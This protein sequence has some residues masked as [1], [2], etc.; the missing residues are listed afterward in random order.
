[1]FRQVQTANQLTALEYNTRIYF[2]RYLWPWGKWNA[3]SHD[4]YTCQKFPRTQ[5]FPTQRKM[6]K[7][8]FVASVIADNDML[9]KTCPL[10]C[11][12]KNH[13]DWEYC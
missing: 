2:F 1:M 7:N 10:K 3:I 4:S 11:R 8:N 13:P 9:K 12:P 6:E 5:A